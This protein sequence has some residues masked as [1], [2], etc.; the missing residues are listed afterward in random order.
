M[1]DMLYKRYKNT[2]DIRKFKTICAFGNTI[3]NATIR[4]Y[5]ESDEQNLL[6]K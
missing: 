1:E 3:K 5:M 2:H 6:A 4:M